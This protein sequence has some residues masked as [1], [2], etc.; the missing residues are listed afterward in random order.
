[1]LIV[2]AWYCSNKKTMDSSVIVADA[3]HEKVPNGLSR[4]H[5]K[6]RMGVRGC[7]HPSVSMS[8]TFQK[9]KSKK[10]ASYHKKDI[11]DLFA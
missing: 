1:M 8:P 5:T 3:S 6:K 2:K 11:R 9:K 7:A 10:S 4:C